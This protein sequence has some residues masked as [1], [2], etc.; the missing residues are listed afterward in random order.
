MTDTAADVSTYLDALDQ[1]ESLKTITL[2]DAGT[3]TLTLTAAQALND[4]SALGKISEGNEG[5]YAVAILDTAADVAADFDGLNADTSVKSISLTDSGTP[6]LVLTPMQATDD[7]SALS[8]IVNANY[9]LDI[10]GVTPPT[11]MIATVGGSTNEAAQTIAGTVM[12]GGASIGTTVSIYDNGGTTPI[13][14]AS[15]AADGNW[16]TR[17]IL[18][19]LGTNR[20]TATDTDAAGDTG[21]SAAV[22]YTLQSLSAVVDNFN[23]DGLSDLLLENT[24]GA[25]VV[26]EIN[27]G[28]ESYTQVAGLGPEWTFQGNGDFLGNGQDQFLI[29]NT[30]GAVD[31]GNV[32]NGQAQYAQVAALGPEWSFQGNG[33]FLDNGQDQFLIENTSGAVDVGNVVNGQAQYTQV[34]ALGPEWTFQGTGDFLGNGQDQFLIENTSGGV[35]VGNVVN[36]QAQYTQVAALG[37]EWTFEGTGDFLG[38]G[39]DQFLIEN[40]SGAVDVG[41]V[42]NGQV[43]YTQVAALGPEW[44]FIGTGDYQGTGTAGF[45]IENTAGA[46]ALATI[47][48]GQ[49]SYSQVG[50]LGPEWSSH[51]SHA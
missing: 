32:V 17:V 34:A 18:P 35:D 2:T 7:T 47:A 25:V 4:T 36:G 8:K 38:N 13:A 10:L 21:T 48:N 22:T 14:T 44:S 6:R 33:D 24:S 46:V 28:A 9:A 41:N 37:P 5:N 42:V 29:E 19:L 16:S 45:M 20:L 27:N 51:S 11:V 49:A 26:G 12:E 31:V 3:P 40:T 23:G 50:A 30:S 15:V 43:Q 39:Q 1:D